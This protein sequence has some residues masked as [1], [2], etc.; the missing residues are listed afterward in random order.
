MTEKGFEF[1]STV[2]EKS[3]MA[4]NKGFRINVTAFHRFL[5]NANDQYHIDWKIKELIALTEKTE[6]ELNGWLELV[7]HTPQVEI[8]IEL[9]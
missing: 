7:K 2:K 4:A 1:L 3:A 9:L 8:V 6:H 5:D